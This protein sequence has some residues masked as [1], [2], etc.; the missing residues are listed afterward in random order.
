MISIVHGL[1]FARAATDSPILRWHSDRPGDSIVKRQRHMAS[2]PLRLR[3][4]VV[5]FLRDRQPG[6]LPSP[7]GT[8]GGQTEGGEK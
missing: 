5:F 2:V 3:L 1:W 8:Q 6:F 7:L 4:C